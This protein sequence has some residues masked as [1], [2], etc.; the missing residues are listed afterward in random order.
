MVG[1]TWSDAESGAFAEVDDDGE[2]EDDDEALFF[3]L[4]LL[5]LLPL[6]S[7]ATVAGEEQGHSASSIS[8]LAIPRRL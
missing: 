3:L 4:F 6:P 8:F 1:S 7:L 5:L 2:E